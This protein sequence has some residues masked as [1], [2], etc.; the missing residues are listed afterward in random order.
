[1]DDTSKMKENNEDSQASI[2]TEAVIKL[3]T[4]F[5]TFD[6]PPGLTA[7]ESTPNYNSHNAQYT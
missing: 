6:T 2:L 4:L 7:A 3:K 5:F 1:M